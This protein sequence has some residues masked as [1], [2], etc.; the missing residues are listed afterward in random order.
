MASNETHNET[1]NCDTDIRK[2]ADNKNCLNE[3]ADI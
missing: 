2:I 3:G 1:G